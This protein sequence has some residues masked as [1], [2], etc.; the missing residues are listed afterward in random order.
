MVSSVS[1]QTRVE[2]TAPRTGTGM[3]GGDQLADGDGQGGDLAEATVDRGRGVDRRHGQRELVAGERRGQGH[4]LLPFSSGA[5]TSRSNDRAV[6]G[7][8]LDGGDQRVLQSSTYCTMPSS[9]SG[10]P[11][12]G[13]VSVEP[14]A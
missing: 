5:G 12:S 11:F 13:T 6:A 14:T 8:Q 10:W 2:S 1:S 9:V 3:A 7:R 4:V